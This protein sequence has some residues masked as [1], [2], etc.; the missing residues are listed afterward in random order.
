M[1]HL[2][3]LI[4]LGLFTG[5]AQAE[6]H[7]LHPA[8]TPP[9]EHVELTLP[10]G[11]IDGFPV[12]NQMLSMQE[13]VEI[14][15][16]NNIQIKLADAETDVRKGTLKREQ[17]KRWP[18]VS[19]GSNTFLHNKQNQTFM[20][21]EMMM[22]TGTSTFFQDL[23]ASAKMPLFTGGK[24]TAGI[25]AA[26]YS[27]T[28]AQAGSSQSWVETASQ[29]RNAYLTALYTKAEHVVHQ[30][31]LKVQDEMLHNAEERYRVGRGLKSDVLRIQAEIANAQKMLNEE[32]NQLN[33]ALFELKAAMG[34]DLG[35]EIEL[36]D[37]LQFVPWSGPELSELITLAIAEHPKVKETQAA[38]QAAEAQLRAARATYLPQITGQVSGSL[39][40]KQDPP[41]MGNGVVGWVSASLP[42]FDKN[43]G[44]EINEAIA[45]V[46]KSEQELKARKLEIGKAIAQAW[47]DLQFAKDNVAL[48]DATISQAQE[49]F[50]LVNKRAI[51]KRAIMVEVQDAALKLREAD[52]NRVTAIYNH[53]IA[54]TKL[55]AASGAL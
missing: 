36:S 15:L 17:A 40:F 23:N 33:N 47:T 2:A 45:K 26:Q 30:Q 5:I 1:K 21:P 9:I 38:I 43:R 27:V 41:M 28:E 29:I 18:L 13:A 20:T 34:I 22:T 55:K 32:H 52:L 24:L 25:R 54:K 19:L 50:R 53:E 16:E 44:S 11:L 8:T 49:D 48:S 10:K 51:A 14:G 4:V 3:I 35:S 42:V 7:T 37:S 46:K 12:V 39:R 6:E 31:H